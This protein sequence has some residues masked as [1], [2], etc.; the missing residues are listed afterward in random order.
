MSMTGGEAPETIERYGHAVRHFPVAVS[1]GAMAGAWARQ[2]AA[3][4]GATVIVDHEISA[5]GRLGQAWERPATSTLTLAMVLRPSLPPEHADVAWL[6]AG[7]GLVQG[8]GAVRPDLALATWWPDQVVATTSSEVVAATKV[9][10]QLG[11]GEVRAAVV[12]LRIDLAVLGLEDPPGREALLEAVLGA[13]DDAATTLA[14]GPQATAAAYERRCLLVERRVKLRL[15][16][17]G[18]SRGTVRAFDRGGRLELASGT[19]MIERISVDMLR[20]L[21]VV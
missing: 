5:L 7:L 19:G 18:E 6:V 21:E 12:T 1:A 15:L 16:P 3:P 17:K 13:F 8:I 11:P 4:A 2:G 20:A 14:E 10:I 9:E